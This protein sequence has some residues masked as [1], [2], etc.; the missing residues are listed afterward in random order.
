MERIECASS[1]RIYARL[2]RCVR[3]ANRVRT[4]A[5]LVVT[6]PTPNTSRS[7]AAGYTI[8]PLQEGG[9]SYKAEAVREPVGMRKAQRRLRGMKPRIP[10][11]RMLVEP[12]RTYG[13]N[14]LV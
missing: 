8:E 14:E 2:Q 5:R 12:G 6:G 11:K 13:P 7:S 3:A 9:L 10:P 4:V 1:S